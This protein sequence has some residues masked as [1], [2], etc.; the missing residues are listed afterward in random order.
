MA[1]IDMANQKFG[2]WLALRVSDDKKSGRISWI[3]VCE[4][5][6]ERAVIGKDLR[7]GKSTSCGCVSREKTTNRIKHGHARRKSHDITYKPWASM[8]E[9]CTNPNSRVWKHYG[10]NGIKV[11][12]RWLTY[13]NFLEDMGSRPSREYSIDRIDPSGDYEPRNCR[14]ADDVLQRIN[15]A[16]GSK[17]HTSNVRGVSWNPNPGRW[18]A[19]IGYKGKQY[20]LGYY[21][22]LDEAIEARKEGEKKYWSDMN[23]HA[24]NAQLS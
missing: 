3:C 23:G 7:N 8:V 14:W 24:I 6:T 11:C 4:C 1:F 5:G 18:H 19:Y 21:K 10:G 20:N 15:S 12:E 2:R 16:S 17:N 13:S 9:R 22:T